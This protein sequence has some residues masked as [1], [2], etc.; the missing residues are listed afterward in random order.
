[1]V[2]GGTPYSGVT[3]IPGLDSGEQEYTHIV[4]TVSATG[5]TVI[6]TP[7]PGM[8]LRLHWMYA[9]NDPALASAPLIQVFLGNEEKYRVYALSKRQVVTGPI[10]GTLNITLGGSGSVAV[11]ALVDEI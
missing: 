6:H 1:M 10:N 5:N 4:A 11:T 8:R 9:I 3:Y 2:S 7:S